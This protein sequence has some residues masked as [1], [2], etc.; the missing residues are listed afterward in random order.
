MIFI[1]LKANPP[2]VE[3]IAEG[4]KL[5]QELASLAPEDRD[6][7]I[8]KNKKYWGKLK[9]Y[10]FELSNGKCWYTEAKEIA[11][12]Y[13]MDHYRPKKDVTKLK[14]TYDTINSK[15]P[16][17]WLAF[18]WQNYRLS[19][20]IPNTSKGTYFPLKRGT[21]IATTWDN[22]GS[23]WPALLDPT[24]VMDVSL[25]AYNEAGEV[26]SACIDD[27]WGAARVAIS[28]RV[29][30]LN[31]V[32]LTDARKEIQQTCKRLIKEIIRTKRSYAATNCS[33]YLQL[34]KEKIQEL[35]NMTLPTSELSAVAR[36][37]IRNYPDDFIKNIA[38]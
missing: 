25:I 33:D 22:L 3:L 36:N 12:H 14:G 23:E 34:Y 15:E 37:Y 4:Y 27:E 17:W 9:E 18:D 21:Q 10:Y 38:G 32:R 20:S 26:C 24:E 29:Y 16:Y 35:R 11:S 7:F 5:T 8:E 28:V 2:P 31:N 6:A 1:D 30:D 19:S 13:H